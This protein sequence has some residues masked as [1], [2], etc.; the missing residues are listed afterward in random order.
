MPQREYY[1][2]GEQIAAEAWAAFDRWCKKYDPEGN[3]DTL[4]LAEAYDLV[5]GLTVDAEER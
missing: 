2:L 4:D 1:H 5:N 3:M